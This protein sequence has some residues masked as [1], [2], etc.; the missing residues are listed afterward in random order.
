MNKRTVFA[1]LLALPFSA[2]AAKSSE[3]NHAVWKVPAGIKKIRVRSWT[4]D[5]ELDIDRSLN[6]EPGEVFR[7]DAIED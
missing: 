5:G 7:I 2:I 4:P 1:G 3:K 6:V